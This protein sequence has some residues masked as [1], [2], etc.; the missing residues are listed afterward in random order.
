MTQDQVVGTERNRPADVSKSNGETVVRFD[1]VKFA[2]LEGKAVYIFANDKLVRAKYVFD[3]QHTDLN[4]FIADF[5]AAEP[6]L[7][8]A[9]GKPTG[10]RAMWEDDAT[11]EESIR[12][13]VQDRS[14]PSDILP[15]DRL[16]G[17]AVS[18][19]QLK[20]YTQ[21]SRGRTKV[22]HALTGE[23]HR[24]THQIEFRSAEL[25]TLENEVVRRGK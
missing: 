18:L 15:S 24:I 12:Y 23:N 6:V 14:R 5:R 8:E 9:Y 17:L 2:G 7:A 16:V 21:W 13:L 3:S 10:E 22:L 25:E 19:G 4:G 1:A 20:L 11:Q